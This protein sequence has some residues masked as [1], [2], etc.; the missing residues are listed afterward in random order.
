MVHV[1][2]R[3]R[4]QKHSIALY[5]DYRIAG[6]RIQEATGLHIYPGND[7]R[8]KQLNKDNNIRFEL[9]RNEKEK[10]LLNGI[11]FLPIN[12]QKIDFIAFYR[13]Y[14]I[15]FP[16]KER[17]ANAVLKKL[18][19]FNK[20]PILPLAA[21]DEYYLYNFKNY[22]EEKLTGETPHNYFKLLSRVLHFAVKQ[23]LFNVN[24]A[25]DVSIKKM[26]GVRKQT[27]TMEEIQLLQTSPCSNK[28]VK[29]AFLFSCYTGLRYCDVSRLIWE[30]IKDGKVSIKQAKTG[31]TV[32][33]DL[34][35][36]ALPLLGSPSDSTEKIFKLPTSA[37]GC[38]KVLKGWVKKVGIDKKITWHC[39]R[40]SLATNLILHKVDIVSVSSV[41]GHRSLSH[42]QRYVNIADSM[43]K[44]AI[45]KLPMM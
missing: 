12:R 29:N 8:T 21:I 35:K 34:H 6:K 31:F 3:S 20:R 25:E 43:R 36:D 14:F 27:L 10:Q 41:M 15:K 22:L 13:E 37:N 44:N 33:V 7:E 24:P 11:A 26:E 17:R 39:A 18:L 32:T 4:K 2:K 19:A 9:L 30:H 45:E 5:L 16:T 1:K 38:N 42:T 28:A 23:G 40:H